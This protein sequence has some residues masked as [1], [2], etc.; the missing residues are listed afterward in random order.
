MKILNKLIADVVYNN[1]TTGLN[2]E[3]LQQAIDALYLLVLPLLG[4][5]GGAPQTLESEF[6]ANID[7]GSPSSQPVQT[8]DGGSV[9]S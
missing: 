9:S 1:D 8:L 2:A 5:D 6:V 7:G 4:I 3:T